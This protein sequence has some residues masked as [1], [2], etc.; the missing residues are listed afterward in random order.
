M[1]Q[2]YDEPFK[3]KI[4][5]LRLEEG[6]SMRSLTEEYG[7]SKSSVN[8]VMNFAKNA[9]VIQKAKKIMIPWRQC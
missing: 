6:R 2:P 4:V 5:R 8:G 9:R 1:P 7:V 3:K